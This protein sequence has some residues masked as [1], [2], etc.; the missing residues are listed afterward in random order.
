M[1][2]LCLWSK[3]VSSKNGVGV[4]DEHQVL[5]ASTHGSTAIDALCNLSHGCP[6]LTNTDVLNASTEPAPIT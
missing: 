6:D 4:I 2:C 3:I 5:N 1:A